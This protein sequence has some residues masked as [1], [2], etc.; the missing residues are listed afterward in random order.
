MI[1]KPTMTEGQEILTEGN[2]PSSHEIARSSNVE[3]K[4]LKSEK[5]EREMKSIG[6]GMPGSCKD[7][8]QFVSIFLT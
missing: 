1:G 6:F 7:K 3:L 5:I 8:N 2:C 4:T